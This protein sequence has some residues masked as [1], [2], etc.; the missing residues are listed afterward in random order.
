[1]PENEKE[2]FGERARKIRQSHGWAQHK[3][4]SAAGISQSDVSEIEA[5]KANPTIDKLQKLAAALGTNLR[6]LFGA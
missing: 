2:S 3:V 4:A 6:S 5:G 1:M